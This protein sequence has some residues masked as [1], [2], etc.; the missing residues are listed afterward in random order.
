MTDVDVH[1]PVDFV[2]LEFT[3]NRLTGRTAEELVNL[4]DRGI[5][6]L[7][8]LLVVGKAEDGSIYGLEIADSAAEQLGGCLLYTSDAAD[9]L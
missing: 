8:D 4:I 5:I 3:G 2:V 7:Y 9:E 6:R 1:G